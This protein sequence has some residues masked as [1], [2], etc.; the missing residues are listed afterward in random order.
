MPTSMTAAPGFTNDERTNPGRPIAATRMSPGGNPFQ[1]PGPRVADRDRG[2][3][4]KQK[5]R[6][7]FSD[8]IAAADD[9][10]MFAGNVDL[11]AAQQIEDPRRVHATR[12]ARFCTSFPTFSGVTP[13]TSF[14][15][16]IASNTRCIAPSPTDSGNGDCTRIPST[17]GSVFSVWIRV[18]I[19]SSDVAAGRC[20]SV[21]VIPS[22]PADFSLLLT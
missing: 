20:D 11:A 10:C 13:S 8:N 21:A 22:S 7:G 16:S 15:G 14:R 17:A 5:H 4:M 12:S 1:V 2:M 9:D 19:S 6:Y 18:R 3:T